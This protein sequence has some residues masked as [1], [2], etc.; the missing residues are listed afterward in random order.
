MLNLEP[1]TLT[2]KLVSRPDL[3]TLKSRFEASKA[4]GP[5]REPQK[6]PELHQER[7]LLR[8]RLNDEMQKAGLGFR[9]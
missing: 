4:L 8:S 7:Q 2:P 1:Q 3:N 5:S 6:P 9:V